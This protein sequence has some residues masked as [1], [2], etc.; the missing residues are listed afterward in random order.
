LGE[1]WRDVRIF[2]ADVPLRERVNQRLVH[3]VG[4]AQ[5]KLACLLIIAVDSASLG[6]GELHRLCDDGGK[7]GFEVER[8]VHRLGHLA[9]RL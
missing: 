6:T 8:R 3:S 5:V 4:G 1:S 7:Y 9:K 2:E